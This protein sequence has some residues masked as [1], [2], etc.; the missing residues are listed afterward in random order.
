[1]TADAC[2]QAEEIIMK[3][4]GVE[5]CTTV[6]GFNLL[7]YVRNTYSGFFFIRLKEW[8]ERHRPGE[9][10]A[11]IIARLNHELG[12]LPEGNAFAFSPP[13]IQGVGTA[14]GVTFILEDRAGR[15]VPFLAENTE[16]FIAAARKRPELARVTTTLLPS[17]PQYFVNVDRD[18]VLSE[19]VDLGQVY[20]T[21]QA[22]MGGQFVNYF[23]R[24]GRQW[25]VYVEAEGDYRTDVR[26]LGQFYVRNSNGD[27]VPLAAVTKV[28]KRGGPEFTMRY[29]LFRSAQ[30]NATAAP[31]YSS[32]QAMK[33]LE[34]VF[35]E[36]MPNEMGFDY[37]GISFQEKKAQEG[38]PPTAIFS[39][40]LLF[41]FLILA[42]LYES[43]SLP[44]SVLLSTPI[45][46]CGAFTALLVRG[47]VFNIYAQIGLI[48]LIG[49][50]AK[51]AILIVEFA[52]NEFERGTDLEEAALTG[53]RLRLRPILMTSF[54]F[55][56]GCLPLA[57][58]SGAGGI[59][60]NVM[61]SG[62]I[63][64]ML[65]ATGIAIFLIPMMFY[66]IEKFSKGKKSD[67][68]EDGKNSV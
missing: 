6:V 17:V 12:Q 27:P 46:V 44:F 52:K 11:G 8:D 7:S 24:F 33:A 57:I 67:T 45:A 42:A 53:A 37:L 35:H 5:Y 55:I 43:W 38:V 40:S 23:N 59:A 32:A 13:A 65:A 60:R 49:L 66:V 3:T 16:K 26:Q 62:V 31:G 19:G 36:T 54:A 21:L 4:P 51:N 28:E 9:N 50:A 1:R 56:L 61:G 14:G 34:E 29:N 39:L 68:S 22:F 58:S 63:G 15:D 20:G 25:Q 10:A 48:V 2:R 18:K 41:V 47:M 30:I 64:G